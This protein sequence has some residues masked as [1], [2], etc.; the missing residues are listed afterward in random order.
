MT[1]NTRRIYCVTYTRFPFGE[2][3]V[4]VEAGD[5]LDAAMSVRL[6]HQIAH[7]EMRITE[8]RLFKNPNPVRRMA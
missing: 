5:A 4:N 7:P 8:V 3:T 1:D 2:C 6:M